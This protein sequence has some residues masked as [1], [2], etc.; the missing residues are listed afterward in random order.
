MEDNLSGFKVDQVHSVVLSDHDLVVFN[1]LYERVVSQL[2][3]RKSE[4]V[5]GGLSALLVILTCTSGLWFGSVLTVALD[6]FKEELSVCRMCCC[7][8]SFR[9]C[10]FMNVG[11]LCS[12]VSCCVEVFWF[13]LSDLHLVV[14]NVW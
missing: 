6:C 1:V 9:S 14:L 10:T 13:V 12:R 5:Q 8:L 4:W 7:R 3:G 2:R 11:M